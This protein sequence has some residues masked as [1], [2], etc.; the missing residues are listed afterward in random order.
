MCVARVCVHACVCVFDI[1]T[2]GETGDGRVRV[3]TSACCETISERVKTPGFSF[4]LFK[5][6][7]CKLLVTWKIS[8]IAWVNYRLILLSYSYYFYPLRVSV[9]VCVWIRQKWYLAAALAPQ[10]QHTN[11]GQTIVELVE[12]NIFIS[13]CCERE[14]F[15]SWAPAPHLPILPSF[16]LSTL[17]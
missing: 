2:V 10:A 8:L 4:I 16:S 14:K 9:H 13:S 11:V 3:V 1:I 12:I 7:S 6:C 5:M 15:K 17:S